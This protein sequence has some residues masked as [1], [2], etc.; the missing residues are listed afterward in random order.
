MNELEVGKGND[1]E[2]DQMYRDSWMKI[3]GDMVP[4]IEQ[5][6][7]VQKLYER[8]HDLHPLA[9][10]SQSELVYKWYKEESK[11]RITK[12]KKKLLDLYGDQDEYSEEEALGKDSKNQNENGTS[13][14]AESQPKD[15]KN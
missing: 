10:P 2:E 9:N 4:M 14:I 8:G 7:Y 6:E 12:K 13:E 5:E 1:S 15:I 3:S 11:K